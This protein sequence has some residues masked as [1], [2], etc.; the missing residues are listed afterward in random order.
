MD[1]NGLKSK[2]KQTILNGLKA[3]FAG[4]IPGGGESSA[5]ANWTKMAEAISGI[6][7]DIVAEITSNAE[8]MPGITVS[9]VGSPAAQTGP[10]TAP[11]KI[12]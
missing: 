7:A 8:V 4:G 1:A 11:G 10:T 5:E 6:A 9:T 3:Q 12:M 2:L